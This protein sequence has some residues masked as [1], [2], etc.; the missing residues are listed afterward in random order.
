MTTKSKPTTLEF[1]AARLARGW[2]ATSVAQA[3]DAERPQLYRAT[4]IEVFDDG[5]RLICTDAS[6]IVSSW[7]AAIGS[8]EVVAPE[9]EAIADWGTVVALD[10]HRRAEG[11]MKFLTKLT[12]PDDA[13]PIHV[14]IT[15]GEDAPHAEGTLTGIGG[16]EVV[17]FDVPDQER[18]LLPVHEAEWLDWRAAFRATAGAIS[19]VAF[20]PDILDRVA[21]I[22]KVFGQAVDCTLCGKLGGALFEIHAAEPPVRGRFMPVRLS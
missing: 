14:T 15:V 2:I 5:V 17:G 11:L 8:E 21:K 3:D 6:M 7:I 12:K 22:G 13:P 9:L 19:R 20:G 4:A 1:D 18:L 10:Q 16:G